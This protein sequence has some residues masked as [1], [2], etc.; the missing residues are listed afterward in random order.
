M[1]VSPNAA[2]VSSPGLDYW[3]TA[4]RLT[5]RCW[6]KMLEPRTIVPNLAAGLTVT[7]IALPLNLALAIACGLPP[8]VGL[9]TGAIAGLVGA[10]FGGSRFSITGPEIALAPITLEIVA[11]H[12]VPGLIAATFMAGALQ[13]GLGLFRV[14]GLVH[15]IP[16]PVIGG[17]LAAVGLLVFDA[18]LPRLLGLPS[19]VSLLSDIRSVEVAREVDG[20]AL[21]L[22]V[23][24]VLA[25]L[26]LPRLSKRVPAPLV[27]LTLAISAMALFDLNVASVAPIASAWPAPMLP[28]FGQVD[29]LGLFPEALALALLASIDSLLCAVATDPLSGGER[30]RTDQELCAQGLA[31]MASACFGGMPVAAAVVR[32]VAAVEAGASTRLASVTQ[33]LLIGVVLL[34]AAPLVSY[35]PL[36]SLAGIL[37]V[38]GFRLVQ[39]RLLGAMWR[40]ARFEALIFIVTAAGILLTDFV[41]GVA[42]GVVAAL[43]HFARQQGASLHARPLSRT[44]AASLSEVVH[45]PNNV[46]APVIRIQGPLFFGSQ[47]SIDTTMLEIGDASEV[48]VDVS[49]VSTVD[50][51]GATAFAQALKRLASAGLT[52]WVSAPG[53]TL[54]PLLRWRLDQLKHESVRVVEAPQEVAAHALGEQSDAAGS[55][56]SSSVV[57]PRRPATGTYPTV[58]VERS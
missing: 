42:I 5:L 47:A 49:R 21:A 6:G 13:V 46:D 22:G 38:V 12:G 25:M 7:L 15:A 30:T 52:V 41:F 3:R 2:G 14:G 4:G 58:Q 35:V 1:P 23:L 20:S 18:Q 33:S 36:V 53:T 27:A 28:A 40:M 56:R 37:L 54:D 8:S 51:S 11:R 39:W 19:H 48:L 50:V 29:L 9:I 10:V 45:A 44:P 16:V 26:V 31:N 17:F 24:V 57:P 55:R 43:A 34:A 32:S